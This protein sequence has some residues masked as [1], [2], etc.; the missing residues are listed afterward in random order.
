MGKPFRTLVR[1]RS[2][3]KLTIL[4]G[5]GAVCA[6]FAAPANA[7]LLSGAVQTVTL[8]DSCGE[9]MSQ[10]FKPWLDL[11]HYKLAPGGD[12][13]SSGSR[14]QLDGARRV[15]GSSPLGGNKVLSLEP[16]DSALSPPICIDGSEAVSRMLTRSE[17]LAGSVAVSVVGESGVELPVGALDALSVW[18]PSL[19]FAVPPAALSGGKTTFRYRFTALGPAPVLID[20]VYV[21][22]RARH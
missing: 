8:K 3:K 20:S 12:F 6:A 15:D 10:V 5:C 7:G 18:K 11:A 22:P 19:H 9:S 2:G 21:D 17:G 13:E 14:W 4:L 1:S 16:G